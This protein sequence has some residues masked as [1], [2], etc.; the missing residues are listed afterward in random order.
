M[1]MGEISKTADFCIEIDFEKGSESPS[2]VF[3]AMSELI[4]ACSSLDT[5]LISSVDA[6]IKP[7][8]LLEDIETGSIKAWLKTKLE[9]VDDEALKN[10]DWKS[11]AGKFLTDGKYFL[12]DFLDKKTKI[13]NSKEIKK[14]ADGLSALAEKTDIKKLPDY[15]NPP[16]EK[17]LQ[18]IGSINKALGNLQN[19]D[20][21][22]FIT[23]EK[24][25]PFNLNLD[26]SPE[27]IEELLIEKSFPN[28][29]KW[30]LKIKKPDY[31]GDS[32]WEFRHD[33]KSISGKI[34]DERWLDDFRKQK[35]L[36]GPGD[37]LLSD[38][39]IVTNYDKAG[40][41]VSTHYEVTKINE[42]ISPEKEEQKDF[43][44]D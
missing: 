2:R 28:N 31:L 3:R 23:R 4:E 6:N 20:S 21:A 35:V 9:A 12:I 37:A 24:E 22:K 7:V 5:T 36:L 40:E 26:F 44:N 42:V 14:L 18:N 15:E 38:V 41:V 25:I 1:F 11:I 8:I 32:M 34:L 13:T 30:I 16:I 10:L 19:G 17:I 43:L 29:V 33:K 27:N 39:R